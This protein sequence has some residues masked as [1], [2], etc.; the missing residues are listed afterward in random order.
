MFKRIVAAID[1]DTGRSEEIIRAARE[2]GERFG[3]RVLVAHVRDVERPAGV[4]A[5]A[6]KPGAFP[7]PSQ[8]AMETEDRARGL[9]DAAVTELRRAGIDAHGEVGPGMG[10]TARE[11]LDIAE[12]N[13]A[14]LIIVGD[15][16]SRLSDVVLGGVAHRI[17]H[18]AECPVL[19]VR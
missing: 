5:V 7:G 4:L 6:G 2:I 8:I 16:N 10:S 17:V 13:R 14:D 12:Q 19:L 1:T 18:L 3:S 11:L 9:V 15:R